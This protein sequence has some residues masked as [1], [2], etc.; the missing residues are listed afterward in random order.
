MSARLFASN[1][2]A[3]MKLPILLPSACLVVGA[4][5][6]PA[7]FQWG[8]ESPI[9]SEPAGMSG[10]SSVESLV[11]TEFFGLQALKLWDFDG[12]TC[13]LQLEQSS[14]NAPN[15]RPLDPVRFCEP[16]QTQAWKRADMGSGHFVTAISVCTAKAQG[17]QI[18]GVELWGASIEGSG[19]LK[20]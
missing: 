13:S 18:H 16:K 19:K 15:S 14:F 8:A 2:S 12:R 7:G 10:A 6:I 1:G 17:P 11:P 3:I 20:P 9:W 5:A 4:L